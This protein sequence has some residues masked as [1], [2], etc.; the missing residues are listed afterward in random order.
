VLAVVQH[1]QHRP[2]ADVVG[3]HPDRPSTRL[4]GEANR[5]EHRARQ[6]TRIAHRRQL[7]P[8]HPTVEVVDRLGGDL[9]RQPGLSDTARAD[10]RHQ[11]VVTHRRQHRRSLRHAT[12]QRCQ[13]G[14]QVVAEHTERSQRPEVDVPMTI[15]QLPRPLSRAR[16]IQAVR[17]HAATVRTIEQTLAHDVSRASDTRSSPP[18]RRRPQSD[19]RGPQ[20]RHQETPTEHGSTCLVARPYSALYG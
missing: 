3:N 19:R 2:V 6:R 12:D 4:R 15:A 17:T 11:P 20:E 8:P 7:H 9:Q 14:R 16:I 5:V 10:Q 13:T 18:C 1:Q